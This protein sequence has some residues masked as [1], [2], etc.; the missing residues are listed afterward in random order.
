MVFNTVGFLLFLFPRTRKNLITLNVACVLIFI[1][2][3]IEK[4][5]GLVIP[6]FIPDTLSEIYEYAPTLNELGVTGGIFAFGALVYTIMVRASVAIDT[7]RLRHPGAPPVRHEEDEGR[8]AR[9]IMST[10]VVTVAPDTRVEQIAQ[11]L[12]AAHISGVP[13]VDGENKVIGVVSES[14]IIFGRSITSLISS[15]DWGT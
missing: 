14:D 8:T 9:D 11:M 1:G 6:G 2:I 3:W 12:A 4:G 5:M 10:N 13:V 7:G 15:A